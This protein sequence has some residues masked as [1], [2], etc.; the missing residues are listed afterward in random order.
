[1]LS[2]YGFAQDEVPLGYDPKDL[3]GCIDDGHTTDTF[4]VQK[5]SDV[6]DCRL[7]CYGDDIGRHDV[8]SNQH[9]SL[10]ICLKSFMKLI[11]LSRL[12]LVADPIAHGDLGC[13]TPF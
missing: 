6:S 5:C 4:R 12:L 13:L 3:S 11:V 2:S 8:S 1:M 9:D 10:L 7:G